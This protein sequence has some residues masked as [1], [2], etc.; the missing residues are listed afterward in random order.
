V[1]GEYTYNYF[2][3]SK[4]AAEDARD[5]RALNR[6]MPG[7]SARNGALGFGALGG[8]L[9]LALGLAGGLAG[10]S[11]RGALAGAIVGL[12]LGTLAGVLPSFI[13]MPWVW[14]HRNDDPAT[15][16]LLVP[17][18]VHLGLWSLAGLAA[19]L[20]FGIGAGC[21]PVRIVEA[22]LAGLVG[23]M[24]GTFIFEMIGAF[25]FPMD[26]TASPFSI[27]PQTRLLARLCVAGFVG[28]GLIRA[29][30]SSRADREQA[31]V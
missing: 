1:A 8:L 3:P 25:A 11:A 24:L 19:G 16:E 5:F 15:T 29:L 9:G 22:S 4:A 28:L 2:R 10:R 12:I 17:L 27:T 23:A 18:F 13:V 7:V 30:P 6:E 20:A 14:Q 31:K 21:R 26:H